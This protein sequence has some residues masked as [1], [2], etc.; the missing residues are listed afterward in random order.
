MR[1]VDDIDAAVGGDPFLD[2]V[3]VLAAVRGGRSEEAVDRCRELQ[4][5]DFTEPRRRIL[6]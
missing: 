4:G 3:R 1:N 6:E 5:F 2:S